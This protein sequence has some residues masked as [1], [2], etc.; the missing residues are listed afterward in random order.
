MKNSLSDSACPL[1]FVAGFHIPRSAGDLN[2]SNEAQ[3]VL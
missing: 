1:N 2:L 3:K